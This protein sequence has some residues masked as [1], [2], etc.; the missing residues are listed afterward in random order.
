MGIFSRAG[1]TPDKKSR[2]CRSSI[3][4]EFCLEM[5]LFSDNQPYPDWVFD[6][7]EEHLSKMSS[8]LIK[9]CR[10]LK[11]ANVNFKILYPVNIFGKWKFADIYIPKRKIVVMVTIYPHLAGWLTERARFFINKALK[12]KDR[13][14]TCPNCGRHNDRDLLA[15]I[16]IKRFGLQAQNLQYSPSVGG[17]EDV[18]CAALADT[19]KRQLL[20]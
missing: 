19:V 18:E 13:E 5:D 7:R 2:S 14:W 3:F 8:K 20:F 17:V 10:K 11:S 16:N 1:V 15:A 4:D 12:L 9:F 6:F